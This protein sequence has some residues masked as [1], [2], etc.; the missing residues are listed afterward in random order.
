MTKN[1][2]ISIE[3]F[4]KVWTNDIVKEAI[5]LGSP[6]LFITINK[7]YEGEIIDPKKVDR[8]KF[9]LLKYLSR[10]SSRCTPFGLFAGCSIG[11]FSQ[12]TAIEL[13]PNH[14]H[15]RQTRFDMNFLVAFSQK[16][17]RIDYIQKQLLWFPNNSIYRIGEQYRY[18]EYIYN[19]KNR[20]EHSLE[21]V[22]HTPY[23]ENIL[24]H[25]KSGKKIEEL[26]SLLINDHISI[27]DAEEFIELLIQNQIIVSEIEPS[28]T[29]QDFLIQLSKKLKKIK[30]TES[31][32]DQINHYQKYLNQIDQKIGNKTQVYLNLSEYVKKT[33]TP[34]DLKYLFQADLY[35]E[36]I[37]NQLDIRF[38]Y[39]IKRAMVI[40]NKMSLPA[41]N[42]TLQQFKD[43][44]KKRYE[45]RE[46]PL[47]TV[48]DTEI[49]IGYRQ[50]TQAV[51]S[52]PFLN[53]LQVPHKRNLKQ[54]LQWNP[55]KDI[56][57]NKL[58]QASSEN[59]YTIQLFDK[60]FK[61]LD[62]NWED[63]PD[64]MSTMTEVF[65][66]NNQEKIALSSIG[67]AS[68]AALLGRFSTGNQTIFEHVQHIST[69][70]EQMHPDK[71]I[72]EIIHLPESRT[73][74]VIRRAVIRKY[75]I[76]YLGKS[77]LPIEQQLPIQDLMLSIK[78]NTL[79]LRSKKHN[80]TVLPRLTNA[81]NYSRQNSLPIYHFLCDMQKQN[82]R[83]GIA[84]DWGE[85][86]EK[87]KFLPRVEYKNFIFSKARWRISRKD[88]VPFLDDIKIKKNYHIK[89]T[90][91]RK[92]LL[93][94]KYVQLIDKDN[95]LLINF[96]NKE[97]TLMWLN[98]IKNREEFLLEEFLFT[99]DSPVKQGSNKYSN[100]C[101][102][103]FYN[104]TKVN[105][106]LKKNIVLDSSK[107]SK[108]TI[109]A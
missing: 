22:T 33:N 47:S 60:D 44:F 27:Q 54:N 3:I 28:V 82:M 34:F 18:V 94:P 17:S 29:G 70:E 39:Q 6:E 5:F 84:F 58:Q 71:L 102:F 80:K 107:L 65:T 46:I 38:G 96:E 68:A 98:T 63:L 7:W 14:K 77:S 52:T 97:S 81:H 100:Q 57:N 50:D 91:W 106:I 37:K 45:T 10:M 61:N 66:L 76:P 78:N 87:S 32:I 25:A 99:E 75:E 62:I 16:L 59:L 30:N 20:R 8:L 35:T 108:I 31:I 103:S 89:V 26:T 73:G 11:E 1:E 69:I 101:V 72:A 88:I 109:K 4:K 92:K 9:S 67:G 48:L 42:S 2:E 13:K 53:D 49:G 104:E 90:K 24:E 85:I 51:D 79:V 95:T 93:I 43:A 41:Q 23:L 105:Q 86:F 83:G 55:V 74:N 56:L 64:S 36:A 15:H 19:N 21:A 12:S 40:L